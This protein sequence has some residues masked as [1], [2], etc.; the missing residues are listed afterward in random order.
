[1]ENP[2][3]GIEKH[4]SSDT[5]VE[6]VKRWPQ[7]LRSIPEDLLSL[8]RLITSDLFTVC[9]V[10]CK[11]LLCMILDLLLKFN[12][13]LIQLSFEGEKYECSSLENPFC[14]IVLA[15]EQDP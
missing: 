13:T 3:S 7:F 14:F 2:E 4:D 11:R 5:R 12:V 6:K 1:M 15:K 9:G 10:I 8:F